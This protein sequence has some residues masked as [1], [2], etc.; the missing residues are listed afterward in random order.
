MRESDSPQALR[1]IEQSL[2]LDIGAGD[3]DGAEVALFNLALLD[4][5]LEAPVSAR[6]RIERALAILAAYPN[7]SMEAGLLQ[8]LAQ[9]EQMEHN[10]GQ[11]RTYFERALALAR[12]TGD[13][14][15]MV[16][17]LLGCAMTEPVPADS[18]MLHGAADALLDHLGSQ[19]AP[20]DARARETDHGRLRALLGDETF[21]EHYAHGRTMSRAQIIAV[22]L[23]DPR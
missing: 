13:Q 2:E 7:P 10:D 17:S 23:R 22:A 12:R 16:E 14:I 9:V 15:I 19:F 5:D 18:A 8:V 1:C 4:L 3:Q 6:S 20:T 11:A 21:A